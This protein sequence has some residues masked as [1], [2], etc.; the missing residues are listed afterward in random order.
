MLRCV[1]GLLVA[2]TAALAAGLLAWGPISPGPH[3]YAD[4]RRLAGV[5]G[6]A[7][8]LSALPLVLVG[9][10]GMAAL[11]RSRWPAEMVRP[12]LMFFVAAGSA[13][14]LAALYHLTPGDSGYVLSHLLMA[15]AFT[16]LLSGFLAERVHPQ[17]GSR[18]ACAIALLLPVLAGLWSLVADASSG[19]PDLRGLL[20]LQLLP[21]LLVPAGAI[22]L[23]GRATSAGDWLLMLVLYA[24]AK[25]LEAADATVYA[26]TGWISG[27]SLMH[28]A[29]AGVALWLAY[30]ALAAAAPL[31]AADESP[32][33]DPSQRV[34]STRTSG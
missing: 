18:S 13:S 10:S 26:A 17:F 25:L 29:L 22:S 11:R 21:V 8:A 31:A 30:R 5:A 34:S 20:L 19:K 24:F 23:P 1:L 27:H 32:A 15:V 4:M 14:L 16:L 6:A 2:M 33:A 28:L 12:W 9:F 3:L 7:N